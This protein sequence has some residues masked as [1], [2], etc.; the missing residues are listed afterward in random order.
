MT[1]VK[2]EGLGIGRVVDA[3]RSQM[4]VEFFIS[5][6]GP[7]TKLVTAALN[8]VVPVQLPNETLFYWHDDS[9]L[10]WRTGRIQGTPVDRRALRGA[11][12]DQYP[13]RFP[14]GEDRLLPVSEIRVRWDR[15]LDDPTD[16]VA[17][18][19]TESAFFVESRRSLGGFLARQ[20]R[21]FS[22]LHGL[23]SAAIQYHP[24]Q[25]SVVRRV[26]GDPV[27]RY[28][29]ADEVGLGKTIEAGILIKQHILERGE[30]AKV[31]VI[32]PEH[33]RMQWRRELATKFFL[34]DEEQIE[35]VSE[36][37]LDDRDNEATML[38]VDEAHH[39]SRWAF[40][41]ERAS[42]SRYGELARR[43]ERATS[44][45]LLS[46]TPVLNEEDGFLAMLHLIDPQG[47]PLGEREAF[48]VRVRARQ[49]VANAISDLTDD[50]SEFF[51]EDVLGRLSSDFE[52][53]AELVALCRQVERLAG[54]NETS[55]HR[56]RA[57]RSLR[58]FVSESYRLHR[59]LLRTRRTDP[60]VIGLLPERNG[61]EVLELLDPARSVVA[62]FLEDW[63]AKSSPD[64]SS[65]HAAAVFAELVSAGFSHPVVAQRFITERIR[66][67]KREKAAT[68]FDTEL[69]L[70]QKW[71]TILEAELRTGEP[72]AQ[73]LADWCER[74]NRRA[75]VFVDDDQAADR[76]F[77]EFVKRWNAEAVARC[78][79]TSDK[80]LRRFMN[81]K[82]RVLIVDRASEEGLNLQEARGVGLFL[83]DLP[84]SA[85]R[86]EQRIGRVDRLEGLRRLTF[87]GF[88][89]VG[90]YEKGLLA[91]LRDVAKAFERSTAPLQYALGEAV[92]RIQNQLLVYGAAAITEEATRLQGDTQ[93]GLESELRRIQAQEALDS[94]ERD[95]GGE[96][97]FVEALGEAGDECRDAGLVALR[98]WLGSALRFEFRGRDSF[99]VVYKRAGRTPQ[100]STLLPLNQA[101]HWF[102]EHIDSTACKREKGLL[103]GPFTFDRELAA[104]TG[105]GFLGVGHPFLGA[106]ERQLRSDVR[107]VAWAFWRHAPSWAA[108]EP[109]VFFA[110]DLVVDL[111]MG[112]DTDPHL[113]DPNADAASRITADSTFAPLRHTLWVSMGEGPVTDRS[114]L[115][116]L[117][118]PY[119]DNAGRRDKNLRPERWAVVDDR[120]P[121]TDWASAVRFAR[122][123]AEKAARE[124][125]EVVEAQ[126][127]ARDELRVR[128]ERVESVMKSRLARLS[129]SALEAEKTALERD[130]ALNTQL[131]LAVDKLRVRV[132][133]AGVVVLAGEPFPA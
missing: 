132:D 26:L 63:R 9:K 118:I 52:G 60:A 23:S 50:A 104:E 30:N 88:E 112:E 58:T 116:A 100:H 90:D 29:L 24:H 117:E 92:Q 74:E 40:S 6:V 110:F 44:V 12:E 10:A 107:G 33:L 55:E 95:L 102:S 32:A 4:K 93:E 36:D 79:V 106:V 76:V 84:L 61:L 22:G 91:L 121:M 51:L 127:R 37:D 86:L 53:D 49:T 62:E 8:D 85:T 87:V 77:S 35:V 111:D 78:E 64:G 59:R 66:A 101:L 56:V 38:V 28:V 70:L 71:E 48:K 82:A 115:S 16:L 126:T 109:G 2:I 124:L 1:F 5:P 108:E 105:A 54:E 18:R 7:A 46:A 129:G 99:H 128:R 123:S 3:N 83:Y 25:V 96:A 80:G 97:D 42:R 131:A 73:A 89:P 69:G 43:A 11:T 45:L 68:C 41:S 122:S 133:A 57:I 120:L 113:E 119:D 72:R 27:Q 81:V 103:F 125:P 15:P 98:S 20:R 67:L 39:A 130:R 14:N 94:F 34:A 75:I 65:P 47:Y 31:C 21:A 17:A 114:L 19:V 13:V